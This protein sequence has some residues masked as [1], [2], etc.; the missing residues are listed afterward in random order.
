MAGVQIKLVG[1]VAQQGCR[2]LFIVEI[3]GKGISVE[4]VQSVFRGYPDKSGCV[5]LKVCNPV[6]RQ[7]VRICID[8]LGVA[9]V[10]EPAQDKGI[11]VFHSDVNFVE[12]YPKLWQVIKK[13]RDSQEMR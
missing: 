3:T 12:T 9:I 11:N 13:I 5:L 2:V 6:A 1:I 8:R 4:L 10:S 7:F